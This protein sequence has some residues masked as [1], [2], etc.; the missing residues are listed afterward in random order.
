MSESLPLWDRCLNDLRY[1]LKENE[2]TM[3]LRP[4]SAKVVGDK[5]ELLAPNQYFVTHVQENHFAAIEQL[6]KQHSNGEISQVVIKVESSVQPA[7]QDSTVDR[8]T[9]NGHHNRGSASMTQGLDSEGNLSDAAQMASDKSLS[10]INPYFTFET[11]VSG[12]SNMLAYKACQELGKKQSQNRHNPLF[13]Y[14]ASG[15]GKT[16]LM[17]SVAHKYLKIGKTFYYFSSEK[18]INQLVYALRNQKIEQFKRKIKRVD[19]LIIDDVHVLAGK[20]KSS[21]EFLSLFADFMVEGKQVILASDRH[22]SQMTEFD[23]RFRSRFSSGLAVSIEPPEMETRMQILQKKASLS[24]VELPKECAL[25]IAQNVVSNVRR[26]EGA[27]NQVVA[28]ANLTG[29]P[30]DLDMVQYALK[31]VIA[32]RS[33]AVSMDNIRKVVAE[34]YDVSVKDLMSKKRTRSIA[35]PR[36]IAMALA[37]ELT[38][39]SFPDIGQSFGGRDHT[40]VMHACDKVAQLRS[41]DPVLDK[42]YKALSMTLQA[43]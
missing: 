15:L 10:Y 30:I 28:N 37:R 35:R 38:K 7:P 42:E 40:T 8:N 27:L 19:L 11:F 1:Q 32:I 25:F 16:H 21:S 33:Q 43:G 41:E 31:D 4:L 36:Q 14:G 39:D 34:Y 23:E 24:G 20:N 12:K 13:L 17:H 2:F 9:S 18:F 26:L 3:W 6:A 5:L 29:N 22:P